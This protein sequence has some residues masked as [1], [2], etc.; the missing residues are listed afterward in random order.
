M[1]IKDSG[2]GPGTTGKW[3]KKCLLGLMVASDAAFEDCV[4]EDIFKEKEE[5]HRTSVPR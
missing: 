2:D 3:I 1:S 5:V 4:K